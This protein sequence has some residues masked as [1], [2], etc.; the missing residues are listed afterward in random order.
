MLKQFDL[1]IT[2]FGNT[3]TIS[4]STEQA[5][6][7]NLLDMPQSGYAYYQ[8]VPDM[9]SHRPFLYRNVSAPKIAAMEF[10]SVE[11]LRIVIADFGE[12]QSSSALVL[13][14]N[15]FTR[16]VH[17]VGTYSF[18]AMV[19]SRNFLSVAV[20]KSGQVVFAGHE[21]GIPF[22]MQWSSIFLQPFYYSKPLSCHVIPKSA[23]QFSL[24]VR[25]R[26]FS[27][28]PASYSL[29]QFV[30]SEIWAM[31][32]GIRTD[33]DIDREDCIDQS[34]ACQASFGI[35]KFDVN[36]LAL[37]S[38]V[39]FFDALLIPSILE[40]NRIY[41]GILASS[42]QY[43]LLQF[44]GEKRSQC[45][46]PSDVYIDSFIRLADHSFNLITETNYG[47]KFGFFADLAVGDL[48]Q[49][50]GA[51]FAGESIVYRTSSSL[52]EVSDK[53]RKISKNKPLACIFRDGILYS[54]EITHQGILLAAYSA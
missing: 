9:D 47:G 26:G 46:R 12:F 37:N 27:E 4:G 40:S 42:S 41:G 25:H 15:I 33:Y 7:L 51:C 21:N 35:A 20:S 8:S 24:P 1:L 14:L 49:A 39:T 48:E 30:G 13:D 11:V 36:T 6:G 23:F 17:V 3:P 2:G 44:V 31:V 29:L 50:I 32:S 43:M 28:F 54:L 38:I 19:P 22:L 5:L 34:G 53:I 16:Q 45:H 10:V 52:Y 18:D